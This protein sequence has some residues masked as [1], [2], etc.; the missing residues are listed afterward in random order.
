MC[1]SWAGTF[2]QTTARAKALRFTSLAGSQ[3]SKEADGAVANGPGARLQEKVEERGGVVEPEPGAGVLIPSARGASGGFVVKAGMSAVHPNWSAVALRE[4][5]CRG[6]KG[7]TGAH[8]SNPRERCRF[9]CL[10]QHT[11]SG[12]S[13]SHEVLQH[14]G[15]WRHHCACAV[16]FS[17]VHLQRVFLG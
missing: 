10:A 12:F 8:S 7:H 3:S 1:D 2:S 13:R 15:R 16:A 11:A 17:S 5:G 14:P 6:A 4:T 9:L